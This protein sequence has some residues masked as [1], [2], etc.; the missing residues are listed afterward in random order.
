M[1][2]LSRQP[3][4]F[5]EELYRREPLFAATGFL[6]A[7]LMIPTAIALLLETR[8]LADV[9]LWEKPLKFQAA[10]F[11]YL[12]TLAFF[13]KWLPAG[14]LNARWYKIFSFVVIAC[15]VYEIAIIMFAASLGVRS[16]FNDSTPLWTANYRVMGAAA[17]I[18]TSATLAYGVAIHRNRETGL[19]PAIKA[20]LVYGLV[21]TF[22]LTV[23]VALTMGG[24]GS[25]LVGGNLSDA[26]GAPIFGW[27]RDGGDLR[28][29]HLFA[30]HAMHFIPAFGW[31]SAYVLSGEKTWPLKLFALAFTALTLLIF[32]QALMGRP[33]LPELL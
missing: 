4:G 19:P 12:L 7:A 10:L 2:A 14:T 25:H 20:S 5:I 6:M 11:V 23:I 13:A 15:I 1:N 32:A 29:P 16:H 8:T 27:A 31:L 17:V 9:N 21:L 33:F 24:S 26:E 22:V 3:M 30:T 18:L 28:V